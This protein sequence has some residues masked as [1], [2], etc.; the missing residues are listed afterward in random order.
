MRVSLEER[1]AAAVD[2]RK[3]A[4]LEKLKK[5][6]SARELLVEQETLMAKVVQEAKLLQQEAEENSRVL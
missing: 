3:L 6:E 5:E 1:L 2:A 4:E